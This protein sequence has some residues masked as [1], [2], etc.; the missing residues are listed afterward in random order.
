VIDFKQIIAHGT[1]FAEV[2]NVV[3]LQHCIYFKSENFAVFAAWFCW[4]YFP[5][6]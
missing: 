4:T 6:L 1:R 3:L 2:S 5:H